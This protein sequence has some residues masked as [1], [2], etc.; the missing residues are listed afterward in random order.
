MLAK[1]DHYGTG[2]LPEPDTFVHFGFSVQLV[3]CE[4]V[5]SQLGGHLLFDGDV[6]E[7]YGW[8]SWSTSSRK[9]K[10]KHT[11]GKSNL[12]MLKLISND[13]LKMLKAGRNW[14]LF[15]QS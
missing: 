2:V 6:L 7:F 8:G 9:V 11:K 5:H 3:F 1:L 12:K 14:N 4:T 10:R 13:L 15:C